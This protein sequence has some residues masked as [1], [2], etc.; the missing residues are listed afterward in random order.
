MRYHEDNNSGPDPISLS[1]E[2]YYS[3]AYFDFF[4][5]G[6]RYLPGGVF[7]GQGSWGQS[8]HPLSTEPTE[9]E[10]PWVQLSITRWVLHSLLRQGSIRDIVISFA[11]SM[12]WEKGTGSG[13]GPLLPLGPVLEWTFPASLTCLRSLHTESPRSWIPVSK[14]YTAQLSIKDIPQNI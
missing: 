12:A 6:L 1:S 7:Q 13:L 4:F 11:A 14:K 5:L 10:G 9:L 2:K 8:Q 3:S